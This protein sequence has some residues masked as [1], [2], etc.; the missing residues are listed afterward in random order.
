MHKVRDQRLLLNK[1][2]VDSK[3]ILRWPKA[4]TLDLRIHSLTSTASLWRRRC[5]SLSSSSLVTSTVW[6]S[7][8]SS[9]SFPGK[10][11]IG[12]TVRNNLSSQPH[13]DYNGS[14]AGNSQTTACAVFMVQRASAVVISLAATYMNGYN[15]WWTI[16]AL[17]WEK[18]SEFERT[19]L[20]TL[21]SLLRRRLLCDRSGMSDSRCGSYHGDG[22]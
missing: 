4:S 14:S 1:T 10:P 3:K 11:A 8:I 2:L 15:N 20:Y 19:W 5:S 17:G 7:I 6:R 13:N 18:A 12:V 21:P 9:L 16:L 22:W